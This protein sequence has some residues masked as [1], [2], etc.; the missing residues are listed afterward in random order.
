LKQ[1]AI[2]SD[3]LING[4]S[5]GDPIIAAGSGSLYKVTSQSS[6]DM[7][8]TLNSDNTACS[9]AN[10]EQ[11]GSFGLEA[12]N[13]QRL[14]I[15]PTYKGVLR[16]I[17]KSSSGQYYLVAN[18]TKTAIPSNVI[19]SWGVDTNKACGFTDEYMSKFFTRSN[20]VSFVRLPNGTIFYGKDG[21]NHQIL[22]Y[23]TFLNLGGNTSNT[24]DVPYDFLDYTAPGNSLQ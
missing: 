7:I 15:S 8:F 4:F 14:A 22:T 2:L 1:P 6:Y 13:V 5:Q 9:L 23:S 10:L 11:L 18:Q 19:A 16:S 24:L 21:T 17:A 3:D 12:N 20:A